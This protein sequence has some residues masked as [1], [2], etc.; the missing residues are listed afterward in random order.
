[1]WEGAGRIL[2]AKTAFLGAAYILI[3]SEFINFTHGSSKSIEFAFCPV[4][5]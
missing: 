5:L 2:R 3:K 4:C 1:M